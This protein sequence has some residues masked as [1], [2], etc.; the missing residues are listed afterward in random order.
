MS[1][2]DNDAV[3]AAICTS[4]R[5]NGTEHGQI[6]NSICGAEGSIGTKI[7]GAEGRLSSQ[8]CN[9]TDTING[10][11]H[12]AEARLQQGIYK[13]GLDGL[14][15]TCDVKDTIHNG[16]SFLQQQLCHIKSDLVECCKDT[17]LEALK[18]V[19]NSR[20]FQERNFSD[21]RKDLCETNYKI[22]LTGKDNLL[23][24]LKAKC[25]LER[26][27]SDNKQTL[28]SKLAACC[29]E[30]KERIAAQGNETRALILSNEATRVRDLLSTTQSELLLLR[31][32]G[33]TTT[34][35]LAAPGRV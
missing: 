31:I 4:S 14:K 15:S 19:V 5:I 16:D 17:Q 33:S 21:I 11:V 29:C 26:Q 34:S 28:E 6:I 20:D 23:E 18:S 10:Q 12:D 27:A 8:V 7:C 1:S 13:V 25:D 24:L 9:S 2:S 32:G 22:A 3:L 35:P 30:L